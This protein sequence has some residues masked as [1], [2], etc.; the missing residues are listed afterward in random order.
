MCESLIQWFQVLQLKSA[1]HHSTIA[2][3]SDGVAMAQA[4]HQIAPDTFTES[5]LAKIKFEVDSNW[6]LKASNLKKVIACVLDYY[7]DVLSLQLADF[8]MPDVQLIAEQNDA[9]QLGRLLQLILG[10]AINCVHKQDYITQIMQL[11]E[12]LQRN[13]MKALQELETIWQG[14]SSGSSARTSLSITPSSLDGGVGGAA[15]V[16]AGVRNPQD[17]ALAQRC[18]EAERKVALLLDEKFSLQQEIF[19]IQEELDRQ[20]SGTGT[21]VAIGL[22]VRCVCVAFVFIN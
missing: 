13:I 11:E 10:C 4:L 17:D 14:Q 12:S 6:R 16:G 19:K 2:E 3:L 5:W 8:P 21:A 1:A 7:T 18:H 15:G 9:I 22:C 20:Q